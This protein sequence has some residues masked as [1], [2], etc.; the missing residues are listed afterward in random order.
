MHWR[1]K[2][3]IVSTKLCS[4]SKPIAVQWNTAPIQK[5]APSLTRN[6]WLIAPMW[7]GGANGCFQQFETSVS[8]CVNLQAL[9]LTKIFK[10]SSR[11]RESLPIGQRYPTASG[12]SSGNIFDFEVQLA[13]DHTLR[14]CETS[15]K[16]W[17]VGRIFGG[18]HAIFFR[19]KQRHT[20]STQPQHST[21]PTSAANGQ[22]MTL[23]RG[24]ATLGKFSCQWRSRSSRVGKWNTK[25][26][27]VLD[28]AN[29]PPTGAVMPLHSPTREFHSTHSRVK[30]V[31]V[32]EPSGWSSRVW[33]PT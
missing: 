24:R 31:G 9:S 13:H 10:P 4:R 17:P 21:V 7:V 18:S 19:R 6:Q 15:L 12:F 26:V 22:L 16:P 28:T 5:N 33:S 32:G 27:Q 25:S 11:T 2:R 30:F 29:V 8:E 3:T 14:W 23:R 1:R 20:E